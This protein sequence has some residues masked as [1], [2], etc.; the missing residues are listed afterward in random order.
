[1]DI[2]PEESM[3][4]WIFRQAHAKEI[5]ASHS[6]G[7]ELLRIVQEKEDLYDVDYGYAVSELE[8]LTE[9]T[10]GLHA[11]SLPD[12]S[13]HLVW[14]ISDNG[15]RVSF[16]SICIEDDIRKHTFPVW[17][18][19][20]S[21]CWYTVCHRHK[22]ALTT[23]SGNYRPITLKN[24]GRC[25]FRFTVEKNHPSSKASAAP[26]RNEL[27]PRI[28]FLLELI[29]LAFKMQSHIDN[30]INLKHS[31]QA[32]REISAIRDFCD[33]AIFIERGRVCPLA[34]DL[35]KYAF[36]RLA[37]E[38][39]LGPQTRKYDLEGTSCQERCARTRLSALAVAACVFG[40]E[41]ALDGLQ[42]LSSAGR[43]IGVL[44]PVTIPWLYTASVGG[45]GSISRNWCLDRARGYPIEIRDKLLEISSAPITPKEMAPTKGI[46]Y[47]KS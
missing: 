44:V 25:A 6:D 45:V 29:E 33:A 19:Q 7:A 26:K 34:H 5:S 10:G 31:D 3:S 1:M 24:R 15:S 12:H 17:R 41:G 28:S 23:L 20:W 8:R 2:L 30:L 11:M 4:S 37:R 47:S 13:R 16:C 9:L 27:I 35:T 21:Y 40:V 18:V 38:Y 43:E 42:R 36:G 22:C 32:W 46:P 14:G 39:Q